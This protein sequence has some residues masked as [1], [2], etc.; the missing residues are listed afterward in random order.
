MPPRPVRTRWGIWI[1]AATYCSEN[2][3]IFFNEMVVRYQVNLK[4]LQ[5]SEQFCQVT[6]FA[7]SWSRS[8]AAFDLLTSPWHKSSRNLK[9]AYPLRKLSMWL[10]ILPTPSKV[11]QGKQNLSLFYAQTEGIKI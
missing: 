6:T 5:M 11:N 2:L 1:T 4:H 7:K 9:N 3:E 8:C 10:K